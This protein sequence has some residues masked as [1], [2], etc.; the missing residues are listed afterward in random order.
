VHGHIVNEIRSILG[1]FEDHSVRVVKRTAN[2]AAH[3]VAKFCCDNNCARTWFGVPPVFIVSQ[4]DK[5]LMV[6]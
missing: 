2:E 4:M 3:L 1:S 6:V 5:D